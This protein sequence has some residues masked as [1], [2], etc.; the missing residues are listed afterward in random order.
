MTAVWDAYLSRV[1][2]TAR[3]AELAAV[4]RVSRDAHLATRPLMHRLR[5]QYTSM[6]TSMCKAHG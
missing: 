3:P 4:A 5:Q 6:Y 2:D 1:A